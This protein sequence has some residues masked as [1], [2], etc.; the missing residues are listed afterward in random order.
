MES[1]Y[2]ISQHDL[3]QWRQGARQQAIATNV[4]MAEVDWLLQYLAGLDRLTLSLLSPDDA[5]LLELPYSVEQMNQL[6]QQRL[7]LRV[8]VQYLAGVVPWRHFLLSVS[9][10]VLIPRPETE[11]LIDLAI[12]AARTSPEIERGHWADLGTG[13]GAI[14]LG[15]AEVF[16]TAS[17]H[18]VDCSEAALAIAQKNAQQLGLSDRIQFYQGSWF[19]PLSHLREQLSGMVSNPPYIPRAMV[20]QLEPEVAAHEPSL[21]LDGGVDGLECIRHLV[22][23]APNYLRSGGIWL[24]EMMAGQAEDVVDLL[25]T[26]GSYRDVAVYPDLAGIDRFALAYRI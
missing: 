6:W 2:R 24:I 12:D 15:L 9:P 21:A 19:E 18:A 16:N 13:S 7:Q 3:W 5:T 26:Q 17:I 23:A 1:K 14:A 4:A 25:H 22:M 10:A 11:G 20:S 8:P